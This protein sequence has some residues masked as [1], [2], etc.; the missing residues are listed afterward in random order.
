MLKSELTFDQEMKAVGGIP[1]LLWDH[2]GEYA[3]VT[4]PFGSIQ[5]RTLA[6]D[7]NQLDGGFSDVLREDAVWIPYTDH[8]WLR[9][10][11]ALE[12]ILQGGAADL[13]DR[14]YESV[15]IDLNAMREAASKRLSS[16]RLL[17][18]LTNQFGMEAYGTYLPWHAFANSDE[19]PWGIYILPTRVAEWTEDLLKNSRHLPKPKPSWEKLFIALLWVTYRHELFHWHV[20]TF[21]L[22][23]EVLVRRPV[24]RPYVEKVREP[25]R[26]RNPSQWWEEALA[27]AVVLDSTLV[28]RRSAIRKSSLR[29]FLI[30]DFKTRFG[31]GYRHFECTSVGGVEEAHRIL[32]AQVA[33]TQIEHDP[34][35]TDLALIKDLYGLSD[36]RVPGYFCLSAVDFMRFQLAPVKERLFDRYFLK[37]GGRFRPGPGD[38]RILEINDSRI[39]VNARGDEVDLA[40]LKAAANLVGLSVFKLA[41]KI[42]V[43]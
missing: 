30:P 32:S 31:D 21:A 38:H 19:T 3:M 40:S 28:S 42:R 36:R 1:G 35:S 11:N 5:R 39:H 26:R 15:G 16:S 2:P 9:R 10:P 20:E 7:D 22:E 17:A 12:E 8:V 14:F 43:G 6:P 23:H 41:E 24:Y 37:Q 13:A 18:S 33:R 29:R 34:R 4:D 25:I 27:Q